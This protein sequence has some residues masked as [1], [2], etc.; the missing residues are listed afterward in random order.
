MLLLLTG[1]HLDLKHED[2]L[3]DFGDVSKGDT[4]F[5]GVQVLWKELQ[6]QLEDTRSAKDHLLG[7]N[8]YI[9]LDSQ[10]LQHLNTQGMVTNWVKPGE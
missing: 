9:L 6:P 2:S 4:R 5:L 8:C 7:R 3:E 1:A 10:T